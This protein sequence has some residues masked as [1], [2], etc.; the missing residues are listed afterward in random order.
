MVAVAKHDLYAI[1]LARTRHLVV[2]TSPAEAV[3][4]VLDAHPPI[5]TAGSTIVDT[6]LQVELVRRLASA[7]SGYVGEVPS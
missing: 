5:R 2:A 4:L 7:A 3:A 1:A 6:T